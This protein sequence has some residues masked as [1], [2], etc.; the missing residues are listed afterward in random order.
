MTRNACLVGSVAN[1]APPLVTCL[2]EVASLHHPA[3]AALKQFAGILLDYG[4]GNG[5]GGFGLRSNGKT[6]TL[7]IGFDRSRNVLV[8]YNIPARTSTLFCDEIDRA[9]QSQIKSNGEAGKHE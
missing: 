1:P 6:I 8:G 9:T 5:S 2:P 4:L 7:H 3:N